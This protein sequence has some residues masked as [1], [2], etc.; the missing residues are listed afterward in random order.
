MI[1]F[2]GTLL[3]S[4]CRRVGPDMHIAG[5]IYGWSH[6]DG[7]DG[8]HNTALIDGEMRSTR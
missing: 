6:F 8:N 4:L 3:A 1:V 2:G 7:I 5:V